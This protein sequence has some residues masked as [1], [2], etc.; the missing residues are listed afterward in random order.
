MLIPEEAAPQFR[1]D[2]APHNGM[3]PPGIILGLGG[4]AVGL[5][6]SPLWQPQRRIDASGADWDA[7]CARD[8]SA[9]VFVGI[10]ARD[11]PPAWP[12]ALDGA[13]DIEAGGR[14]GPVLAL[15]GG[16]ERQRAGGGALRQPTQ[17]TR[18][19]ADRGT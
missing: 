17:Q 13:G 8:Y 1:D 12:G 15:A 19:S 14:R 10:D 18:P 11:R 5:I 16:H 4:A 6:R 2:R 3:I 7:R 9:E